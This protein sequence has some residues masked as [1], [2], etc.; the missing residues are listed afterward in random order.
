MRA[1]RQPSRDCGLTPNEFARV[2]RMSP[3]RVRD[4]I[5]SGELGAID[6]SRH[7]CG[8]PRYVILPQH[9]AEW[10]QRR[11]AA[12]PEA[13]KPPRKRKQTGFVDYYPD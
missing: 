10:E 11:R 8:R 3:D 4:M 9:V 12:T 5:R 7:R 1:K 2:V 6:T 13:P